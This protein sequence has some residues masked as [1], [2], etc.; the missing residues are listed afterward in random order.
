[1]N[2]ETQVELMGSKDC[3]Q[4]I[5]KGKRTK[6]QRSVSPL[7][8][9]KA[10][11][12]SSGN[13][14]GG[15]NSGGFD[16][17][18][19]SPTNSIQYTGN[20]DQEEEYLANCLILLAQ[21][22][23]RKPSDQP[24]VSTSNNASGLY[25]YQCKTCNR[26]FPSFQALGGHRA[27]H[28]KLKATG[29]DQKKLPALVQEEEDRFADHSTILSL[30]IPNRALSSSNKSRVHECSTCG[31]EFTS[32]QALGGHMRRHRSIAMATSSPDSQEGKKPTSILSL[33]LNLPAPEDD[34]RES[35]LTPF[36][37]TGQVIVFSPSPLLNSLSKWLVFMVASLSEK[38]QVCF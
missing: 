38:S 9:T 10:A 24:I 16:R 12:S 30:Q 21:G 20:T 25:I 6:R 3:T 14:G 27:S 37:S 11:S 8:L 15:D 31:A 4:M 18:T 1:M 2:M 32:G 33:D 19:A 26:C 5:M 23:T 35:K 34:H 7:A 17:C 29:E 13:G 28:K 36:T 22:Q